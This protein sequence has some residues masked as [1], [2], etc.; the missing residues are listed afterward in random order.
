MRRSEIPKPT[1]RTQG[2]VAIT[3]LLPLL[4]GFFIFGYYGAFRQIALRYDCDPLRHRCE[5]DIDGD[6]RVDRLEV[7]KEPR[8]ES[9]YHTRL[10]VYLDGSEVASQLLDIE[11]TMIDN[12]F[13]THVAFLIEDGERKLIIYDTVN[14]YQFFVWNGRTLVP[15]ANPSLTQLTIRKAMALQDDTGGF[16]SE[17]I[18][19][20]LY[21]LSVSLFYAAAG[22]VM[23]LSRS[24]KSP[25]LR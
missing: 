9:P 22:L 15:S 1:L 20:V 5:F 21:F 4:I 7:V 11:Y 13:R 23:L 2:F 16:H 3:L 8:P 25:T 19:K 18:V 17:I 14:P 10:K 12:S 6:G 24:L